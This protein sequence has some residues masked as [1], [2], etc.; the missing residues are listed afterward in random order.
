MER[1]KLSS[2]H[3]KSAGYDEKN[4]LLEIEF[5]NGTIIQYPGVSPEVYRRLVNSPSPTSYFR[6]HIEEE[7][8]GRR[9]K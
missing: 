9:I 7:Y 5:A 8:T 3:L 6:D 1:R 2:G 4:R